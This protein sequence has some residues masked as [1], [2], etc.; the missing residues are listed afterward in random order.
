MSTRLS[1]DLMFLSLIAAVVGWVCR[2]P[3]DP[4][5]RAAYLCAPVTLLAA[6]AVHLE[7]AMADDGSVAPPEPPWR[8]DPGH[9]CRRVVARVAEDLVA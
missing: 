2:A 1:V 8:F 7:A 4:Q 6:T 5:A 3:A 9:A